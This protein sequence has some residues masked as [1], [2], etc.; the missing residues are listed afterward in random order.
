MGRRRLKACLADLEQGVLDHG[1]GMERSRESYLWF[2]V[3][4][5]ILLCVALILGI[6][7]VLG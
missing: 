1:E 5:F 7:K 4:V 2:W 6:L 3:A